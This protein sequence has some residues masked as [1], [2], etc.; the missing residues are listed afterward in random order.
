MKL[1]SNKISIK[2]NYDEWNL[3]QMKFQP[4]EITIKWN[5]D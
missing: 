3:G 5:F 2:W 1:E 4:N